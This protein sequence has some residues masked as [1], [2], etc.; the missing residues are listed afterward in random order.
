MESKIIKQKKNL[1]L[2][3]EELVL[4]IKND[5]TPTSDEV[6]AE[7]GKTAE[8]TVI[9]KIN[10]NFGKRIF[11]IE[12][13]VYDNIDA[14]RKIETIP[15]KIRKKMAA[16]KKAEDETAKKAAEAAKKAEDEAK[17]AKASEEKPVEESS[18]GPKAEEKVEGPKVEEKVET[19][20]APAEE[21]K[22]EEKVEND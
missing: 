18:E 13:V 7:I 10:T 19:K 16:D 1:F 17:A 20:E 22:T 11:T 9:K 2:E 12:A 3:R 14:K 6:K 8:L 21:P 5:V 4:E 15:Q